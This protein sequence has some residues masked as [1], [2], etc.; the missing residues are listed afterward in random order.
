MRRILVIAVGLAFIIVVA[1]R[2]AVRDDG[3]PADIAHA[4]AR[5]LTA[6]HIPG[7]AVSIVDNGRL[8]CAQ[9]FGQSR[10]DSGVPI[11]GATLFRVGSLTKVVT[12]IAVV[13]EAN[14][15][16]IPLDTPIGQHVP[17]LSAR[18]GQVTLAQLL[19][20]TAGFKDLIVATSIDND[21]N[22]H[23]LLPYVRSWKDEDM[24]FTDPGDVMSYSNLG[25]VLAGAFLEHVSGRPFADAVADRVLI[26]IGMKHATFRTGAALR[27]PFAFGHV[28]RAGQPP[29]IVEPIKT[30]VRHSPAGFLWAS[31]SDY[32]RLMIALLNRGQLEGRRVLAPDVVASIEEPRVSMAGDPNRSYGFGLVIRRSGR[33]RTFSHSGRMDGYSS[34][35]L[36]LPDSNRGYVVLRNK[37]DTPVRETVAALLERVGGAAEEPVSTSSP[38]NLD[39]LVGRY[40]NGAR[41]IVIS[42]TNDTLMFT[43]DGFEGRPQHGTLKPLSGNRFDFV[44]EGAAVAPMFVIRDKSGRVKYVFTGLR[45][46]RRQ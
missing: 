23:D 37:L 44:R 31:A 27:V 19:S 11:T 29:Q 33:S 40:S 35:V 16:H 14:A 1:P 30:D 13:S 43:D 22:E 34:D 3:C 2:S 42:R 32:G 39:E 17:G 26:P 8:M 15:K 18:V 9:G 36:M 28:G 20:H 12:A 24:F 38:V 5:D 41:T 7:I 21:E 6:Q 10:L 45:A 4:A 25:F 46:L